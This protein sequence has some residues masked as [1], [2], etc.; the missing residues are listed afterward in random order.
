MDNIEL[1]Y[2]Y[3][4]HVRSGVYLNNKYYL[5]K[6]LG[7]GASST[8]WFA[9]DLSDPITK[10]YAIKIQFPTMS[11]AAIRE[12]EILNDIKSRAKKMQSEGAEENIFEKLHMVEI[13]DS[14]EY[15]PIKKNKYKLVCSVFPAYAGNLQMLLKSGGFIKGIP[16]ATVKSIIKQILVSL[17]WVNKFGIVYMDLKPQNILFDAEISYYKNILELV[18][19]SKIKELYQEKLKKPNSKS[20]KS[21]FNKVLEELIKEIER[22]G[23][24]LEIG[25]ESESD[26]EDEEMSYCLDNLTIGKTRNIVETELPDDDENNMEEDD[27]VSDGEEDDLCS[28]SEE[29][30]KAVQISTDREQQE[31]DYPSKYEQWNAAKVDISEKYLFESRRILVDEEKTST[32]KIPK[33][34]KLKVFL[35]DFGSAKQKDKTKD[36]EIQTRLYRSP[37]SILGYFINEKEEIYYNNKTDIWSL[38]CL[39]Y[40]LL[41]GED[42]F[43]PIY[44]IRDSSLN[45]D[46]HHLVL[47]YR[48]LG[49]FPESLK[50]NSK[51]GKYLFNENGHISGVQMSKIKY[52][53]NL[54]KKRL[55]NNCGIKE[56][57]AKLFTNFLL[58]CLKY[59]P[60]ERSD[61]KEL[62]TDEWLNS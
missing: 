60:N 6:M 31:A 37:E 34:L 61:E 44:E 18:E 21:K 1:N 26:E 47:F 13:L 5:W 55:V 7:K 49:D 17:A 42:L 12:K 38:G 23:N 52:D 24:I 33:N 43:N 4:Q 27:E 19:D 59:D 57:E 35:T 25:D 39:A 46:I 41:T 62:L 15:Y 29:D 30:H 10:G 48:H 3:K 40:Q 22:I 45:M 53:P 11:K 36:V 20:I 16:P 14:F 9:T 8:V 56:K 28:L 50:E 32:Y 51:R 2:N 58:K 54:F